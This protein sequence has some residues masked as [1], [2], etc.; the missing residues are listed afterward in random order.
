MTLIAAFRTR[1]NGVLLC[2]DREEDDGY[3]KREVDKIYRFA[4]NQ[5]EIFLAAAGPSAVTTVAYSQIYEHLRRAEMSGINVTAEHGR[6]LRECLVEIHREYQQELE[7]CSMGLI[8]VVASLMPETVPM[9]YV[10]SGAVLAPAGPYVATGTGKLVSDYLAH[11][12]YKQ[13]H[14]NDVLVLVAGF[15]CREAEQATSGVGL[16]FDWVFI[17]DGNKSRRELAP[18]LV[19]EIQAGIPKLEEAI[20]P[21]WKE[22]ATIPAWLTR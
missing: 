5:C 18:D 15:I 6:L 2:A 21:Y 9:V 16:G 8:A 7:S 11:R 12:L 17:H 4:M 3:L 14:G 19:R 1:K 13:E 22:R 10:S 20:Y